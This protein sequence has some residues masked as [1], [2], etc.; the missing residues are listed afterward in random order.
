MVL[1]AFTSESTRPLLWIVPAAVVVIAASRPATR[2]LAW[3]QVRA[4]AVVAGVL[5]LA[6]VAITFTLSGHTFAEALTNLGLG[7]STS[8]TAKG[9]V[10]V[11]SFRDFW[12]FDAWTFFAN[13]NATQSLMHDFTR[14]P[15]E[16]A[17]LW[18]YS[19]YANWSYPDFLYFQHFALG[20]RA[21]RIEHLAVIIPGFA[22]LGWLIGNPGS[23]RLVGTLTLVTVAV[24]SLIAGVVDVE[25]RRVGALVPLLA[26]GAAC[27]VWS[28]ADGRRW[29][30]SDLTG[31][32]ALALFAL[33][34]A[35]SV[36][37]VLAVLPV[38]PHGGDWLLVLARTAATTLL[39]AWVLRDWRRRDEK[40]S[41]LPPAVLGGCLLL[42]T[43]GSQLHA[44]EWRAWTST[45]RE[46]VRQQITGL[47]AESHM[48]PW[49]I[50]DFDTQDDAA[51]AAIYVNGR[52]LKSPGTPMRRWQVDGQLLNWAPYVT[53]EQMSGEQP[54][55]W[56]AFPLERK[57]LANGPLTVEIRPP[58]SG[59]TIAGDYL[60]GSSGR[61]VGPSRDPFL[62]EFSFWR[63]GWNGIDPRIPRSQP[64]G[65]RYVSSALAGSS[66]RTG[67]LSTEFGKQ[68]GR[69]RI[70]VS[71]QPF[72]SHTNVLQAPD[73]PLVLAPT[74]CAPGTTGLTTATAGAT[75]PYACAP[76]EGPLTYYSGTGTPLGASKAAVFSHPA[77]PGTLVDTR[78]TSSGTIEVVALGGPLFVA[79]IFGA[80]HE[81]RYSLGFSY[82]AYPPTHF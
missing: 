51:A 29:V 81:L 2:A 45:I 77:R 69:F 1:V 74:R 5:L 47:S 79:N 65:A 53:L 24:T 38:S 73:P 61:Y 62:G 59:L 70:Y 15:G 67:D 9:Q 34:W 10:T 63:W 82:P 60:A 7:L 6:A 76:P 39:G 33:A 27:F 11:L 31:I 23:R 4:S 21:Q 56:M 80:G 41:V 16:F 20:T 28:L 13:A 52:L 78:P 54:H 12:P 3:M 46:P 50:A 17:K 75:A 43:V 72:G 71:Q 18:A 37:D 48:Q 42:L 25:P 30:R 36:P 35:T 26:L 40:F 66:W 58:R 14:A 44:G 64:L 8:G 22:G 49:V 32:L 19:T 55:T 68:S 57:S